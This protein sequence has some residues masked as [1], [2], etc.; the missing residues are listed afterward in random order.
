VFKD[1]HTLNT[2]DF[3]DVRKNAAIHDWEL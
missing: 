2:V 1:G 3:D